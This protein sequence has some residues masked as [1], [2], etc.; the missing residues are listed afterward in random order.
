MPLLMTTLMDVVPPHLRGRMMGRVSIVMSLAPAI[1][2]RA[3]IVNTS[4]L[5]HL[6]SGMRWDDP[7]FRTTPYDKWQAYGQSKTA[8]ALLA[9]AFWLAWRRFHEVAVVAVSLIL[10]A[11]VFITVTTIVIV[12]RT[13]PSLRRQPILQVFPDG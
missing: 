4:S 12:S 8:C 3:R 11:S 13:R 10:E 5:G 2:P 7:H 6:V 9:V 1:G